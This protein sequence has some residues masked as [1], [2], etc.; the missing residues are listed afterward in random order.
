MSSSPIDVRL[1]VL[2]GKLPSEEPGARGL[3]RVARNPE[4][5]R[6]RALTL[7]GITPATASRAVYQEPSREG[8][9]PFA[10]GIGMQFER[11]LVENASAK[12][13]ELYRSAGRLT[14]RECKVVIIPD[15]APLPTRNPQRLA[16]ALARREAETL[17]LLKIKAAGDRD[18]AN[19]IVKPRIFVQ[20]LGI[21]HAI[22]PDVLVAADSDRFYRPV[23][24]KSYPDRAGKTDPADVRSACRQ[25]AVGV[26]ALRNAAQKMGISNPARAIPAIGDLV[27]RTPGSMKPTLRPMTL[28]SEV[29]SL[30][31]AIGEAPRNLD[32]LEAMIPQGASL[33]SAAVLD[34]IPASYRTSC[35]EHCALAG[36]CKQQAL[37]GSE[38]AILG[39]NAREL[40]AAAGTISRALDLMNGRGGDPRTLEERILA[41]QLQE[42]LAVYRRAI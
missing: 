34:Q 8:Q 30:E 12:L 26:V 33:D 20:L 28:R 16:A 7:V 4:C 40:L 41:E 35:K 14:V 19:L 10:L 24:V 39:D 32:E 37:A 17:R 6:L 38:P 36:K 2:R 27:L 18:A 22:E 13:L 29:D 11:N 42:A 31:R 25:A 1:S 9:S 21:G 15:F 3:E 23:E 5:M